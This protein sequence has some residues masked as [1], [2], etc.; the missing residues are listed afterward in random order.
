M[1]F[2][3]ALLAGIALTAAAALGDIARL[4]SAATGGDAEAAFRLGRAYKLGDGIAA[5]NLQAERWFEKAAR[6]GHAKG[7]GE[8]GLV[9]LQNGKAAAAL[10]WLTKAAERGDVRAQ[11]GLA[12]M[13]FAGNGVP[14]SPDRARSWMRRAANGGLPAARE[15]L[16]L[17][18]NP[19]ALTEEGV[20]PYEVVTINPRPTPRA[21][22]AVVPSRGLWT[23]QLGTF[24]N[25]MNA[26]RRW[27]EV[28]EAPGLT[29][30]FPVRNGLTRL[31]LGPF[32]NKK[33][34]QRFCGQRSDCLVVRSAM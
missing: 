14:A 15:A 29:A 6:L 17:I 11:Y 33:A 9:L 21:P 4:R 34:A 27:R 19:S 2:V 16:A 12:T 8:Y 26:K 25:A 18:N 5:D 32:S 22:A 1:R 7:G 20:R 30:T 24:A 13:L 10:P 31:R 23:V 3:I 28:R